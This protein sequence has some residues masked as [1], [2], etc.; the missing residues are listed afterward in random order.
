MIVVTLTKAEAMR[1]VMIG[2]A[3]HL[4]RLDTPDRYDRPDDPI[5]AWGEDIESVAG[6]M[7]VARFLNV[8]YQPKDEPDHDDVRGLQVR[9]TTYKTGHLI[10]HP[11][12]DLP[13]VLVIGV[14]P[15]FAIVGWIEPHHGKRERF[16]RA[17]IARPCFMVPQSELRDP[18]ELIT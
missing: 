13:A 16:W 11:D 18:Q 1:A 12:D 6:E 5:S 2:G 3:R 15:R 8:Y 14:I 4:R 7:V 17:D 9:Q 10:L